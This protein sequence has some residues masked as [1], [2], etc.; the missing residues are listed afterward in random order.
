MKTMDDIKSY[1]ETNKDEILSQYFDF[2]RIPSVSTG[3]THSEECRKA[4]FFILDRLQAM[5]CDAARLI[6]TDGNPLVYGE[7]NRNSDLP[8]V[9][10]YGHYDVMPA[11]ISDGWH[12][13]PFEPV[14]ADD[15]VFARGADDN[16]G[17]LFILFKSLEYLAEN[18]HLNCNIKWLIE[19]EEECGSKSLQTF[20]GSDASVLKSD[21]CV[22]CDTDMI[23][24]DTP[25]IVMS[26]RGAAIWDITLRG[27]VQD[28]HSGLYGG[29]V[30]NPVKELIRVLGSLFDADG[31]V[32]LPGFYSDVRQYTQE[33]RMEIAKQPFNEE[34]VKEQAG[35]DSLGG[36]IGYSA[37]E[38]VV[39][40]P[41]LEI[42]G[43]SG[44]YT[45]EGLKA[46][47]PSYAKAKVFARLVNNQDPSAITESLIRYFRENLAEGVRF[48]C[49]N[50]TGMPGNI[51][52]TDNRFFVQMNKAA[53]D[54][55]GKPPV[56][57]REGGSIPVVVDF[58]EKLGIDS[59]LIGFGLKSDG[60]HG[61][62]E[63]FPLANMVKGME[64]IS[65]FFQSF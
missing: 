27:P 65:A 52:N 2:L 29:A 16:K 30:V 45:D 35:V 7:M 31:K 21:I 17:Q 28:L 40:R 1:Y 48:E 20:L 12:T 61:P 51:C 43:L 6:E 8:T 46:I 23:D 38:R 9:L 53:K 60:I 32:L 36:E 63:Q 58:K 11:D 62:N 22:I 64:T 49:E 56:K 41:T 33:E 15:T 5:N 13:D 34:E 47:V 44:G 59:I 10:I 4:A 39:I 14:L 3:K 24:P 26:L 18:G 54:V 25:A 55:F 42:T 37:L 50:E 19:G 57:I